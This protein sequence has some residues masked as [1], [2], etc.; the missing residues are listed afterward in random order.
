MVTIREI[1]NSEELKNFI[2]ME[3]EKLHL[4]KIGAPWCGPCRQLESILHN[5]DEEKIGNTVIADVNIDEESNDDIAN[6]YNVRSI[7]VTLF[8]KDNEIVEKYVGSIT[9]ADLY[10]KIEKHK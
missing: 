4:V 3:S 7:P 10:N 6:E 9:E 5:L 8:I 2:E 1:K